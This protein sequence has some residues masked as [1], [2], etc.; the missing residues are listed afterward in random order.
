MLTTSTL[1]TYSGIS[2]M[3]VLLAWYDPARSPA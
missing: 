3:R 1:M 2:I